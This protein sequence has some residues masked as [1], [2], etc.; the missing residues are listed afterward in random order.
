MNSIQQL[1][2]E[3][4]IEEN[5]HFDLISNGWIIVLEKEGESH[6]ICGSHFDLNNYVSAKICNDKYACYSA[7]KHHHIPVCDYHILYSNTPKE[8]VEKCFKE[9]EENVVIKANEGSYGNNMFHVTSLEELQEKRNIL[10]ETG[11][12]I[13][14]S[15]YYNII[16]EYR[17]IVLKNQIKLIYGKKRPVVTGD[18][19]HSIYELLCEFNHPFFQKLEDH[20]SLDK[21]LKKGEV[22]EYSWQHNLSRGAI[23]IKIEEKE[24]CSNLSKLAREATNKLNLD[25]VS[26]DIVD[27]E[28]KGLKIL[29]IN[30][31]VVTNIADYFEDGNELAKSIYREAIL[32]MFKK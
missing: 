9:Y 24:L 11:R 5:I 18:G 17:V 21:I 1:I 27:I 23:P 13:S 32:E 16:C 15:P 10:F 20:S 28:N 6:Y 19:V 8:E 4:C 26:V 2:K 30:S 22:Y 14:M 25:F 29:E 7:L 31:G 3:I 12:S